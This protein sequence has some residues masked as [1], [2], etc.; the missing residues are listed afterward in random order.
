MRIY[1]ILKGQ[2]EII[3]KDR[4]DWE[5]IGF[6]NQDNIATDFRATGVLGILNLLYLIDKRS[7]SYSEIRRIYSLSID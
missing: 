3:N 1:T 7:D 5:S 4:V 2:N 6:Q